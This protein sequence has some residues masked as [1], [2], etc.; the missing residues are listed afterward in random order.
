MRYALAI[1]IA[2]SLS[3]ITQ[4]QGPAQIPPQVIQV[5][6]RDLAVPYNYLAPN[7]TMMNGKA[8]RP[9]GTPDPTSNVAPSSSTPVAK[10][11]VPAAEP[12]P[13]PTPAVPA[14]A[15]NE[16]KSDRGVDVEVVPS[17]QAQRVLKAFIP[18]N[19]KFVTVNAYVA[20]SSVKNVNL[21]VFCSSA[22][23]GSVSGTVDDNGNIKGETSSD[24]STTCRERHVYYHYMSLGLP[25]TADAN[26]AYLVTVQC[27]V[28][29]IWDHCQMPAQGETYPVVLEAGKHGTF[30]I[31]AATSAKLGDKS[32]VAKF[33]VLDVERVKA[34]AAAAAV[35]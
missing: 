32:K 13:A 14:V 12:V 19:K 15:S 25:D 20:G 3:V 1:I 35:K 10:V 21:G 26:A 9:A 31:Y 28:R 2:S 27:T 33:A 7:E 29:M 5:E 18:A 22:S 6:C 24:G 16:S 30:E 23:S 17:A 4:A 8:C 11:S 34:N